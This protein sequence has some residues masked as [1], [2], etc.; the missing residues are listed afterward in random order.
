MWISVLS[1]IISVLSSIISVLSSIIS[2]LSSIIS[3]LSKGPETGPSL[4]W[5]KSLYLNKSLNCNNGLIPKFQLCLPKW[6][7]STFQLEFPTIWMLLYSIS[8]SSWVHFCTI[9]RHQGRYP[10]ISNECSFK[11]KLRVRI[12]RQAWHECSSLCFDVTNCERLDFHLNKYVTTRTYFVMKFIWGLSDAFKVS[13]GGRPTVLKMDRVK[14]SEVI[15]PWEK[16]C[17]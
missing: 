3:L 5:P 16:L 17:C 4:Y 14:T 8:T 9:A 7:A 10:C 6:K 15:S 1:S 2:V 13:S 12:S 11:Q